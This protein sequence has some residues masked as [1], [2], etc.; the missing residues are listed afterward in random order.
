MM[1]LNFKFQSASIQLLYRP[2]DL[3]RLRKGVEAIDKAEFSV[4]GSLGTKFALTS[5][6]GKSQGTADIDGAVINTN[7]L[8]DFQNIGSWA[9]RHEYLIRKIKALFAIIEG[10]ETV[11]G[12][13]GVT[14]IARS[15]ADKAQREQAFKSLV[16]SRCLTQAEPVYDFTLRASR[17]LKGGLGFFN[18]YLNSFQTRT[19]TIQMPIG[20]PGPVS[21]RD[22]EGALSEEGLEIR[23][24][25]NNKKGLYA[26]K[27][28]WTGDELLQLAKA[29]FEEIRLAFEDLQAKCTGIEEERQ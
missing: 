28:D 11:H 24:D 14:M 10:S 20:V 4:T 9:Q 2:V 1:A 6:S 21:I 17:D 5:P 3:A 18:T 8:G 25:I 13:I 19:F 15:P 29:G 27:R 22:W 23:F 7:F 12:F 26:G 16:P